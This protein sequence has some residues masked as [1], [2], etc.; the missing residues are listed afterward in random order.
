[1]PVP[2]AVPTGTLSK[3]RMLTKRSHCACS[4]TEQ[5]EADSRML[6]FYY[7]TLRIHP[8]ESVVMDS[9]DPQKMSIHRPISCAM[10]T[11][12]LLG[13]ILL[14]IRERLLSIAGFQHG[15]VFPLSPSPSTV[16]RSSTL[17]AAIL[18]PTLCTSFCP[19]SVSSLLLLSSHTLVMQFSA[20]HKSDCE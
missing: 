1:M 12:W 17:S 3:G 20:S 9:A 11:R 18:A 8:T 15:L 10:W 2:K 16:T 13:L 19:Q 6:S 14:T 5:E 7:G 4:T